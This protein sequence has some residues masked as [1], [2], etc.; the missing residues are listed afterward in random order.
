MKKNMENVIK[1]RN[2]HPRETISKDSDF[3]QSMHNEKFQT[4]TYKII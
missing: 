4:K 1:A 2:I 3:D